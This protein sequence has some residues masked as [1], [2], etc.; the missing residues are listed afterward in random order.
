[1]YSW[2]WYITAIAQLLCIK[3]LFKQHATTLARA[4]EGILDKKGNSDD[5]RTVLS[6]EM[7]TCYHDTELYL[8]TYAGTIFW[9][10]SEK[11]DF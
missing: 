8:G 11:Q 1:M 3:F 2:H 6:D 5:S 7:L 10:L 4:K 9:S